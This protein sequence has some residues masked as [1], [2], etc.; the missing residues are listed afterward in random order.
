[1]ICDHPGCKHE[2]IRAPRL[3]V[4]SAS[5]RD[6]GHRPVRV[7]TTLHLCPAHIGTLK[8]ADLLT[9]RL[10]A[11]IEDRCRIDRPLGFRP[12]FDRAVIEHVLIT[13]PEYRAFA[14]RVLADAAF[15]AEAGLLA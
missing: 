9:P 15:P 13:T 11:R 12:D 7:M 6:A 1:M 8:A 4:P 14:S 5:P 2:P 3:V 10:K